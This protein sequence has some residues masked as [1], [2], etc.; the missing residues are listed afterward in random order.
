SYIVLWII[1]PKAD[2]A[3]QKYEMFGQAGDFES[4]KK[5][6]NQAANEMKGVAKDA[7]GTLAKLF[8][9][10]FKIILFFIGFTLIATGIGLI[11]GCVGV[12]FTATSDIP[13]QFFGYIVDYPW[14]E[15]AV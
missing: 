6:A 2:T 7:S 12:L 1:L 14:Q 4:I 11:I 9:I 10:I 3:S 5:N 15:W 8:Q 13:L